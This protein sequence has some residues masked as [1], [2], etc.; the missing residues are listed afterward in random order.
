[1]N[2]NY[3]YMDIGDKNFMHNSGS[4]FIFLTGILVFNFGQEMLNLLALQCPKNQYARKLGIAVYSKDWKKD[5]VD[6]S[7]KLFVESYFDLVMCSG[8]AMH[9]FYVDDG[10]GRYSFPLF[11]KAKDDIWCSIISIGFTFLIIYYPVK[12]YLFVLENFDKLHLKKF[13]TKHEAL[14]EESRVETKLQALYMVIFML[15]RF[16]SVCV[17]MVLDFWPYAQCTMLMTISTLNLL[18]LFGQKP[19]KS[20]FENYINIFNELSIVLFCHLMTTMLNIAMPRSLFNQLGWMLIATAS[21][22]IFANMVLMVR[23]QF[24]EVIDSC[25]YN[26][27]KRKITNVME[28]RKINRKFLKHKLKLDLVHFEMHN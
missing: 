6:Q 7:V 10:K 26:K 20:K 22:N 2:Q 17:L 3:E 18:Y 11:W 27:M 19:L 25:K 12:S 28:S 9:A 23:Q 14:F 13:R 5:I 21:F 24:I 1:L 8:L 4:Y 15:R 16:F